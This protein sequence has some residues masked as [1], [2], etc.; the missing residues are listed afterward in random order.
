MLELVITLAIGAG[1]YVAARLWDRQKRAQA[2][3]E[4]LER[5][6]AELRAGRAKGGAIV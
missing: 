3:I 1:I 2:R 5:N 4:A 6:V